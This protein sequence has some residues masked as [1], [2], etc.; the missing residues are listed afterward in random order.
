MAGLSQI[1]ED[2]LRSGQAIPSGKIGWVEFSGYPRLCNGMATPARTVSS[3]YY[4][5][6]AM[7]VSFG[8][9]AWDGPKGLW[10]REGFEAALFDAEDLE[11]E[12]FQNFSGKW[13]G[14]NAHFGE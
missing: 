13:R 11:S 9:F 14:G 12:V 7:T 5:W 10:T 1:L 4:Q 6:L 3:S 2:D 8:G